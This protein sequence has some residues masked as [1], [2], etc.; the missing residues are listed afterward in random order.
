VVTTTLKQAVSQGGGQPIIS[1]LTYVYV[2]PNGARVGHGLRQRLLADDYAVESPDQGPWLGM[3]SRLASV[4]MAVLAEIMSR[5]NGLAPVT[6]DPRMHHAVGALD[7]LAETLLRQPMWTPAVEDAYGAYLHVALNAVIAPDD[8]HHVPIDTILKFREKH[9]ADLDRFRHHVAAFTTE[10]EAVA[11]TE[12]IDVAHAQLQS[13]YRL[14][15]APLLDDLRKELRSFG[16]SSAIGVLSLKIDLGSASTTALGA[17]ALAGGHTA[18]G[19]AALALFV[20][21]YAATRRKEQATRKKAS[22][23]AYLLAADRGLRA[24]ARRW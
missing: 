1:G 10:I 3:N 23:V 19:A 24:P 12:S 16:V 15:T 20:V 8:L 5:S 18:I 13:L 2:G 7:R 14:K 4:Y 11:T 6:D 9:A 17:A 22:P 21:P